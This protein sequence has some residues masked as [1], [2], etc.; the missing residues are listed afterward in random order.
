MVPEK[1]ALPSPCLCLVT[2]RRVCLSGLSLAQRAA[3][4]VAGGARM[5]QLREK[6]LPSEELLA[7]ARE[8][9]AAVGDAALFI[10]NGD[11][12]V[13]RAVGAHG[14][15]LPEGAM[16]IAEARR[17]LGRPGL[18]GRSVHSVA[19]AMKAQGEGADYL[20]VGTVFETASKPGQPP[21][22]LALLRAVA[23]TVE[24]PFLGIGGIKAGNVAQ[25]MEG[26]ARGAAVISALLAALDPKAAARAMAEA[27]ARATAPAGRK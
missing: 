10:I 14:V 4:A 23:S 2:D 12:E 5:V 15:H 18:V 21:E 7:L 20:I 13:A 26:G 9:R 16:P 3:M 6:D 8:L 17:R 24:I 11:P 27:M 22:G 19:A 1:V 25:V